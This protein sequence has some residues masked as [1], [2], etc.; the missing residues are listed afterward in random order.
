M[1]LYIDK[2]RGGFSTAVALT[3]YDKR[4]KCEGTECVYTPR[5]PSYYTP[6]LVATKA[7]AAR[8]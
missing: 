6:L 7:P 2:A 5:E 3:S 1:L 4:L 8:I